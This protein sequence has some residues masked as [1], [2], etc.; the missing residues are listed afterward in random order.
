MPIYTYKCKECDVKQDVDHGMSDSPVITCE[1]CKQPM[2]K[3]PGF[4]AATFR[5]TG[6]GKD[7]R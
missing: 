3:I 1:K 5:G 4:G 2:I 6:W 7:A